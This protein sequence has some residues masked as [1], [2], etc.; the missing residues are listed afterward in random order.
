MFLSFKERDRIVATSFL[1]DGKQNEPY[2]KKAS[3]MASK[4]FIPLKIKYV[5]R[6]RT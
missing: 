2:E 6:R 3:G 4:S 5:F 1:Y